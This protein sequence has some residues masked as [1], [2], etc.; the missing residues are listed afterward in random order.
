MYE[1]MVIYFQTSCVYDYLYQE[2]LLN[3]GGHQLRLSSG[4]PTMRDSLGQITATDLDT[5]PKVPGCSLLI[6][7][8]P[9]AQ[10]GAEN[11]KLLSDLLLQQHTSGVDLGNARGV[12]LFS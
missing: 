2:G 11:L 10:V 4:M 3:V 9:L 7:L 1:L 12:L 6:R 5:N 8:L